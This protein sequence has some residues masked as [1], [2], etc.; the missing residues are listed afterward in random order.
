MVNAEIY[1][2]PHL[3]SRLYLTVLIQ[4]IISQNSQHQEFDR[5]MKF[6]EKYLMVINYTK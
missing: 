3:T 1:S 5:V 2:G 4:K 6:P